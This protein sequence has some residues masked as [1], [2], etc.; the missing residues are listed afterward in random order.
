MITNGNNYQLNTK[1]HLGVIA[2]VTIMEPATKSQSSRAIK[3]PLQ[4]HPSNKIKVLKD[5]GSNGDLFFL[6]KENNKPFPYLTK[7]VPKS[8]HTSNVSLQTN[9][10]GKIR[11]KFCESSTSRECTLQPAVVEC[12]EN[13]MTK[14]GFDLILGSNTPNELGI[15]LDFGTKEIT[16][17]DISL[18]MSDINKLKR[19]ATIEMAWTME[20]SIYQSMSKE[21]QSTLKATKHLMQILDAKYEKWISGQL[22]KTTAHT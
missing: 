6:P 20:N 2:L 7:Q 9:G 1:D 21:P 15:V 3:Q 4:N 17:A 10:R 11:V 16:L 12:N 8:S 18:P 13:N 19:R 14:P 22:S 5:S